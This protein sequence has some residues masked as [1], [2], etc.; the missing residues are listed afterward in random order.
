MASTQVQTP[1]SVNAKCAL[2]NVRSL[3]NKSFVINELICS[4][5]LDFL[6]LTETWLDEAKYASTLIESTPPNF[7]FMC[8]NRKNQKGGGLASIFKDSFQCSQISLGDFSSFEYL[9]GLIT[10]TPN[11]LL[12]TIYRPPKHSAK[13]FLE[14]FGELL[15]T[16]CLD[17]D[18]LVIAGDFN[19]HVDNPEIACARELL[20]L[21]DNF[22]LTTCDSPNSLSWSYP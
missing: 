2:L 7:S 11:I 8:A 16:V 19:I 14:E 17:Y 6:L 10:C 21:I 18:C 9:C 22:N 3:S 20:T 13:V 1:P 12:L 5:K 4:Y 15:S